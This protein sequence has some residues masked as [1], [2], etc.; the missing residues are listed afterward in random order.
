MTQRVRPAPSPLT[1]REQ[2]VPAGLAEGES[3]AEIARALF[4]GLN[5]VDT[6]LMSGPART[7]AFPRTAGTAVPSRAPAGPAR[8]AAVG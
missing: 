6:H 1:A 7:R 2:D 5:T 4:I 3:D 8:P